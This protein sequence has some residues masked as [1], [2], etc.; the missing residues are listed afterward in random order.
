[1]KIKH[2]LLIS[3]LLLLLLMIPAS[4]AAA[5]DSI[6]L[7]DNN[8]INYETNTEINEITDSIDDE[9]VDAIEIDE[10]DGLKSNSGSNSNEN[11]LGNIDD[12]ILAEGNSQNQG[13]IY[14]EYSDYINLKSEML[15]Y[16]FNISDSNTI[17]VNSS[18]VG[19]EE[20]GTQSNPFKTIS[21]AYNY[22]NNDTNSKTNI[23]LADGTYTVSGRMTI[24]KNLNLIGQSTLNTIIDGEAN[25]YNNGIFFISPPLAY[26]AISPLVNFV[27]IT[28]TRGNSYYGGAVYI[29][30]SAVNFVYTR[31]KNNYAKDYVYYYE[32]KTY[33][34]SGGAIYNDKGFVRIYNSVFEGNTANG[35]S[36]A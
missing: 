6:I 10:D 17:F 33:P 14:T 15:T 31:F 19:D 27:N 23:F 20:L 35:S 32:Q 3:L 4:F 22:F 5:D 12:E 9:T 2:C 29:N 28:F 18:Y 7:N 8:E 16:D 24:T 1:M 30:Q 26:Y 34:A 13:D 11:G 36:D 21:S 25:R